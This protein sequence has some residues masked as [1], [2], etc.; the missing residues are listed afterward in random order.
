MKIRI[1]AGLSA[2]AATAALG[3]MTPA[4]AHAAPTI[5]TGCSSAQVNDF[6]YTSGHQP[7]VCANVGNRFAWVRTG[8]AA[9]GVHNPGTACNGAYAVARTPQGK[10]VMCAAGHWTYG[11]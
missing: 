3:T 6:R 4:G 11:P 1:I 8:N 9:P 7:T 10:A 5:G 2:I